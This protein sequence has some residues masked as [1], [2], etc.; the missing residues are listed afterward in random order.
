MDVLAIADISIS[1][2]ETT[3]NLLGYMTKFYASIV[4]VQIRNI[5]KLIDMIKLLQE[6]E[7]KRHNDD[8]DALSSI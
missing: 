4:M 1:D 3:I 6:E 7:L 2:Y 5:G 8:L